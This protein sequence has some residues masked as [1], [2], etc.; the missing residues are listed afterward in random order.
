M[1]AIN[2]EIEGAIDEGVNIEYLVAPVRIVKQGNVAVAMICQRMELGEPDESGRRRPVPVVGSEFEAPASAIVA[3]ISQEPE[4]NGLDVLREG[5]D[6]VKTNEQGQVVVNS[7]AL[8]QVYAGGDALNLG[9]V[10]IAIGNGR[11]AAETIHARFRG[12]EYQTTEKPPIIKH[13][14]MLLGY[15]ADQ[16]RCAIE[17]IPVDERMANPDAEILPGLTREQAIQEALR[18]MSCASCFDC[19]TCWSYC[20]DNAIV[21]ATVPGETYKLKLDFC[22]GCD[23]CAENCPCGFIEMH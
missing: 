23:K 22:Q 5:R 16:A 20:Q 14:K 13:D 6:W 4:F 12:I 8:D 19:G 15:Y 10:T 21:K 11:L 9:L 18:C 7:A 1:P 2:E 3:A 17:G